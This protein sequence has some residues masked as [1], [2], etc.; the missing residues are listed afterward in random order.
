VNSCSIEKESSHFGVE[1]INLTLST[2]YYPYIRYPLVGTKTFRRFGGFGFWGYTTPADTN[3]EII[4]KIPDSF[5]FF[6]TD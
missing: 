4:W 1:N 6:P 3:R 2:M 5:M